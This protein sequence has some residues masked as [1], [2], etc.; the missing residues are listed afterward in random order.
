MAKQ[1]TEV[2]NQYLVI[3]LEDFAKLI[4]GELPEEY[5]FEIQQV[6]DNGCHGPKMKLSSKSF[7]KVTVLDPSQKDMLHMIREARKGRKGTVEVEDLPNG[8][9]LVKEVE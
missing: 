8:A 1:I 4:E 7:L 9:K 5:A 6:G 3:E 2:V